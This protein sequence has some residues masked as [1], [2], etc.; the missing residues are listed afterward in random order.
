MARRRDF[1]TLEAISPLGMI[2]IFCLY[3]SQE[4][5]KNSVCFIKVLR[6]V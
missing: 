6:G 4:D 2:F 1:G 3:K 5:I